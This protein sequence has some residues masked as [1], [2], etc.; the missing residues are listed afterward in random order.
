MS[1]LRCLYES[2]ANKALQEVH[3]GI[4]TTHVNRHMM[5]TQLQRAEYFWMTME[6]DCKEFVR[7]CQKY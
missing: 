6:K 5:A 7:K 4:C 3:G 2:K 1:L